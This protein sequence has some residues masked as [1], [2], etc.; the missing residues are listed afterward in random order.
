MRDSLN[1][2]TC[3]HWSIQSCEQQSCLC[4]NPA[5]TLLINTS[6]DPENVQRKKKNDKD[7]F[8]GLE[9]NTN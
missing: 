4:D 5:K 9:A 7:Q 3:Y 1:L 2:T 8:I 6:A